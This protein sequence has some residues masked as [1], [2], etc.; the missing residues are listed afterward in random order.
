M[1]ADTH[2]RA[3]GVDHYAAYLTNTDGYEVEL[4]AVTT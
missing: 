1:F 3:G 4:V 2:P